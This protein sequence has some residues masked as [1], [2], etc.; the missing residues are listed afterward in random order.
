MKE[1]RKTSENWV[2]WWGL[3]L[4]TV[5]QSYRYPLQINSTGTSPT[6]SDTPVVLQAGKFILVLPLL[7][8]AAFQC[9]KKS[10]SLKQWMIGLGVLFLSLY[11]LSKILGDTNATYV[12][13]SF[14]MLFS[15]LLVWATDVVSIS[16]I[17]RYLRYLLVF[18]LGSTLIEVVLFMAFGRLPALAF[19]GT[20]LIRFGGFLDDPN[21]FAAV[22]F[23]LMGWSYGRFKGW[24]RFF[25]L[26]AIVVS[27]LLTQSW[28]GIV[29][30]LMV[31]IVWLP[32][33]LSN[34]PF[35][36]GLTICVCTLLAI[37]LMHE[38]SQLPR[39]TFE[40]MLTA[41]QGSIEGHAFP[42]TRSAGRW[43]E[44][45]MV[46]DS[47]YTA[48][49]SWWA[50]ALVNFGGPWYCVFAGLVSALIFSLGKAFS[51]AERQARPIYLGLLLFGCYFAFGS[52]NL[53]F[54]II[55]PVNVMFFLFAFLVAFGKI[56]PENEIVVSNPVQ[57]TQE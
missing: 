12:D 56:R 9:L 2:F 30:L 35:L 57:V 28:T 45:A 4:C 31:F 3:I 13:L 52:L 27:L 39:Q 11:S 15:L 16:T 46:G 22:L 43:T 8:I 44:W 36:A 10:A 54:P 1:V 26:A 51:K 38:L 5:Y 37:L 17:D 33:R 32:I 55:F 20:Y 19:E 29:F 48:Y 25:T 34:R 50:G 24:T 41:K 6:Y 18:A 21:G 14:W 23:L 49:E 40:D 53:P 47:I 42:W 7:L